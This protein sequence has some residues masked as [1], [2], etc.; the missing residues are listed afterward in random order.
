MDIR[1]RIQ[2]LIDADPALT[3][4]GVS[5]KAGLGETTLR[6]FLKGMTLSMTV[7]NVE[8]VAAV[9]GKTSRYLLYGEEG[10]VSYI[11]DRIPERR[12]QQALKVLETFAQTG[13]GG[14]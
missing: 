1:T 13:S 6:N 14:S 7:D 10:E 5:L 3:V 4:R 8:K 11:W 9:L 12:R 2:E